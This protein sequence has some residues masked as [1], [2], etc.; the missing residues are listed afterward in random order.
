[1]DAMLP[2]HEWAVGRVGQE[3]VDLLHKE[4]GFHT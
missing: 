3:V 4:A 1:M 2:V